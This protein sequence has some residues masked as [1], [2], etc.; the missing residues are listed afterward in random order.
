MLKK[1]FY[2]GFFGWI[3]FFILLKLKPE[4]HFHIQQPAFFNTKYFFIQ[5]L[6]HPG[7]PGKY[8]S[9]YIMQGFYINWLGSLI[10]L[11]L[12]TLLSFLLYKIFTKL[13]L[14]RN[15]VFLIIPFA[16]T[17][18]LFRDYHFP[19]EVVVKSVFTF[20]SVFLIIQIK[21]FHKST[22]VFILI[23]YIFLYY[24]FGSGAALVFSVS[25]LLVFYVCLSSKDFLKS[26]GTLLFIAALFPSISFS[27]LFNVSYTQAFFQLLPEVPVTQ[28]YNK[29]FLLYLFIFLL[30]ILIFTGFLFSKVLSLNFSLFNKLK[31]IGQRKKGLIAQISVFIFA[32]GFMYIFMASTKNE[33]KRNIA[34]CDFYSYTG[35]WD[36]VIDI[37]LSDSEYD[38]GINIYYNM[39]LDNTGKFLQKFFDYP[40]LLGVSS[41]FPD[42]LRTPLYAQHTCDY[43]FDI[44]YVSKSQHWAYAILTIE[45]YNARAIKRLVITNLILSNYSASQTYLNV[46]SHNRLNSEFVN[47]YSAF[48]QDTSLI[49]NDPYLSRKR[50]LMPLNFAV[51]LHISDRCM[52]LISRDSTNR[53]AYE[54]LQMSYLLENDLGKFMNN[55]YK[56][57]EFYNQMPQVYEQAILMYLYSVRQGKSKIKISEYTISQFEL[58]LKTLKQCNNDK[59][60]AKPYLVDLRKAYFYYVTYLSPRVTNLT[61]ETKME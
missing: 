25:G 5:H 32:I 41:I 35:N 45:P 33:H 58:F 24:I 52:D 30:P 50:A 27:F 4:L 21:E 13:N 39:A 11:A 23:P 59:D 31:E 8:I 28:F 44:N 54:H 46:L 38:P 53:Q 2:T 20:L 55:I 49:P 17:I 43:Y 47:H 18:F 16:L 57:V 19:F 3:Y 10:I 14:S 1:F 15:I 61:L 6:A 7:D 9:D 60:V 42:N 51:P 29:S 48:I 22:P 37:A 34:L 36:K 26:G 56:S 40:Q 12:A